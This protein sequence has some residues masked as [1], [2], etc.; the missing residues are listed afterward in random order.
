VSVALRR[1]RLDDVEFLAALA[2]D[3]DVEPFLAP[4]R[5][6]EPAAVAREVERSLAEPDAFGRFVIEVDGERAGSLG[7]DRVSAGSRI[8]ALGGLAVAQEYR[9]RG[10]AAEAARA[11]VALL[12]D[13]L[14]YHR[15]QLECYGFNER[16]IR[17]A[18][19]AGF[20][21]EGVRRKAYWRHGAWQDG[22]LFGLVVEDLAR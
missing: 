5:P 12:F 8:A 11:L 9:G 10:V 19:R 3:A 15:A 18:E 6:V 22:V 4:M 20:V 14:G 2:G 16:A 17:H 7:F 21:R 1:A 13:E